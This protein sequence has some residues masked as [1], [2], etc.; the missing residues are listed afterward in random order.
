LDAELE[1]SEDYDEVYYEYSE[2]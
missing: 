1:E 2:E